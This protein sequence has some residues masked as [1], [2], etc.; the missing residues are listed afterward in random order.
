[1][2][3]NGHGQQC[4]RKP[5]LEGPPLVKP[6]STPWG[7]ALLMNSR[8]VGLDTQDWWEVALCKAETYLMTG[9]PAKC[10]WALLLFATVALR[11]TEA[12][13]VA[14]V[15]AVSAC[16]N[17]RSMPIRRTAIKLLAEFGSLTLA[18]PTVAAASEATGTQLQD[19]FID[20]CVPYPAMHGNVIQQQSPHGHIV[21]QAREALQRVVGQGVVG[22]GK[23]FRILF[24]SAGSRGDVQPV[25]IL[26]KN[27]QAR[28]CIVKAL[29]RAGVCDFC[30][31]NGIDALP[32]APD[33]QDVWQSTGGIGHA[34]MHAIGHAEINWMMQNPGVVFDPMAAMEEF[35][36]D[37][38]L[39]T[40]GGHHEL[41]F[42][43]EETHGVPT[44]PLLAFGLTSAFTTAL[45]RGF[46]RAPPRPVFLTTSPSLE[47]PI[48]TPGISRLHHAGFW[49]PEEDPTPEQLT[50]EP[51]ASL[52]AF[53]EAGRPPV[54]VGWGSMIAQGVPAAVMLV[55]ALVA[56][57]Q[58][59]E[60][61]VVLGGWAKLDELGR[62]LASGR[63]ETLLEG[64]S[65]HAAQNADV[66]QALEDEQKRL[67][68][69]EFARTQCCFLAV[70]PHQWLF[71][72]CY[73]ILHHGG[74]GT[75]HAC[76]S[77]GRPCIIT[78]I[79]F[80][81]FY[82]AG[83]VE[84]LGVGRH[85]GGKAGLVMVSIEALA[86][87]IRDARLA[88]AAALELGAKLRAEPGVEMAADMLC[89]FLITETA[90]GGWY[91]RW[92]VTSSSVQHT[93]CVQS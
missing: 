78:P 31:H 14:A 39:W 45:H 50:E 38:I 12:W 67:K 40:G 4:E 93:G 22:G 18:D 29:T 55:R 82:W 21:Q 57:E 17:E 16:L 87:A 3:A 25:V 44:I 6:V 88:A 54:V 27:L 47:M 15:D 70:A 74:A 66:I 63:G 5:V 20:V 71:P 84:R 43:Y 8:L 53:L 86:R 69:E 30:M 1:M 32:I 2:R 9:H 33:L 24:L 75:T 51:L 26:A 62:K 52:V 59:G 41:V 81:Q 65:P 68:L 60:R 91:R 83:V 19:R 49:S 7:L 85:L 28:G 79:A 90:N 92:Q 61:A 23:A 89:K 37:A 42:K 72:Q 80:D 10:F 58:A 73:C 46:F 76:L 56:V 13:A 36:P 35:R 11:A 77:A 48:P 64:L 34:N